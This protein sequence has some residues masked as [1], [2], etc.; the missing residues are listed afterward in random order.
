MPRKI[1]VM[2]DKADVIPSEREYLLSRAV[3]KEKLNMMMGKRHIKAIRPWFF[4]RKIP[5]MKK[6]STDA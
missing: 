4:L 2:A 6:K 1:P 5:P 3:M